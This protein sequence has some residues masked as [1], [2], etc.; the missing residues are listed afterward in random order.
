MKTRI[1]IFEDLPRWH[2]LFWDRERRGLCI[3]I[4]RFF[5]ENCPQK[6]FGLHF[7]GLECEREYLP[8]FDRCEPKIGEAFF[9][10]N[11]SIRLVD[12]D[13]DWLTYQISI[14][15]VV[16]KSDLACARCGGTGRQLSPWS[17]PGPC[18]DCRGDGT[19]T[20]LS[21]A[22][23][24]NACRSLSALFAALQFPLDGLDP[25]TPKKQLFVLTSDCRMRR[26]GYSVGGHAS[27][28]LMRFLEGLSPSRDQGA[29]LPSVACAMRHARRLMYGKGREDDR[30]SCHVYGGQVSIDCPGDACHINTG[31]D[32]RIGSRSGDEIICHNLDSA[33]QQM[34]MLSGMGEL[35][36]LYEDWI[37]SQQGAR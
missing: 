14:P 27:P 12:E 6:E 20:I 36:S 7:R 9:G 33:V 32:R 26:H 22:Q 4:H 30:F 24:D 5:L 16:Q 21:H 15:P 8:L 23:I 34:M 37:D 25:N 35:A 18:S 10:I 17:D 28:E 13:G 31:S 19:E 3:R 1:L 11:D 29:S 2:H